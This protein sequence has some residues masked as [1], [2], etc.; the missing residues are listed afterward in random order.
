MVPDIIHFYWVIGVWRPNFN[1][2]VGQIAV[3]LYLKVAMTTLVS[4]FTSPLA[5]LF[6]LSFSPQLLLPQSKLSTPTTPSKVDMANHDL[7]SKS[8]TFSRLFP[9]SRSVGLYLT[10]QL[11]SRKMPDTYRPVSTSDQSRGN[12]EQQRT[13]MLDDEEMSAVH[14][15]YTA[16]IGDQDSPPS[17][18]DM[19]RLVASMAVDAMSK[20]NEHAVLST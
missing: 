5:V 16:C 9:A 4:V 15:K 12:L 18:Q 8:P 19:Y 7:D 13:A 17:A 11:H 1:S 6:F 10:S 3:T 20:S 2:E 14:S